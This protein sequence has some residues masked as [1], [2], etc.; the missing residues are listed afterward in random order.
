VD[1][2]LRKILLSVLRSLSLY[3]TMMRDAGDL[4][5]WR[6]VLFK[7]R[8]R[9]DS[10]SQLAL[11]RFAPRAADTRLGA[12]SES[13]VLEVQAQPMVRKRPR[14]TASAAAGEAEPT[15]A[16]PDREWRR[17]Q[18]ARHQQLHGQPLESRSQK[19]RRKR[20]EKLEALAAPCLSQPD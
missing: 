18:R 6:C 20:R 14:G 17:L 10:Q 4:S 7:C 19:K 5:G 2:H 8:I 11:Q 12:A 3:E 16:S 15:S 13:S 9:L 1:Y